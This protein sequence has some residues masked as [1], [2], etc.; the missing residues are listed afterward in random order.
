VKP[1]HT[2]LFLGNCHP[3]V[4]RE[5]SGSRRRSVQ[6]LVGS[7]DIIGYH[8]V[9]TVRHWSRYERGRTASERKAGRQSCSCAPHANALPP[10]VVRAS[11]ARSFTAKCKLIHWFKKANRPLLHCGLVRLILSIRGR[12][13]RDPPISTKTAISTINFLNIKLL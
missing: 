12:A 3:R 7:R 5:V 10:G 11:G 13:T 2:R 9:G 1:S 4:F 8:S 6:L